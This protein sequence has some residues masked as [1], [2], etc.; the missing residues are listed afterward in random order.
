MNTQPKA[1][2]QPPAP[3]PTL[4]IFSLVHEKL[5]NLFSRI[6]AIE[7]QVKIVKDVHALFHSIQSE[8]ETL[9]AACPGGLKPKSC[10]VYLVKG[11]HH[12]VSIQFESGL[13]L[14]R[15]LPE[16]CVDIELARSLAWAG[17]IIGCTKP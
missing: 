11:G 6:N 10:G 7:E 15:T 8:V 13:T 5:Q 14:A 2:N 16:G 9:A 3:D 12:V 4:E 1:D 17:A